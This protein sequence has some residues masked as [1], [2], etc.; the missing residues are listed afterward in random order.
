M[1]LKCVTVGFGS[2]PREPP[3][4]LGG[5]EL[6]LITGSTVRDVSTF[7]QKTS[8]END[9]AEIRVKTISDRMPT[10]IFPHVFDLEV[11][12]VCNCRPQGKTPFPRPV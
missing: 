8:G 1:L 6:R 5:L 7:L 2:L 4:L 12:G 3:G 9:F 11:S 10:S